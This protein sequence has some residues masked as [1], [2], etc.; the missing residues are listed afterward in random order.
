MTRRILVVALV[1]A[2]AAAAVWV[3]VRGIPGGAVA[4]APSQGAR[5]VAVEVA[6]AVKKK[7]PVQL[8]ALGN[9]SPIASVAVRPRIDSEI[10][11]I[12][13]ADGA[14]VRQGDVLVRLDSRAIDAQIQQAEGNLARD[15]AQLEG[16]ERDMRR[17]TDLVAKGATPILNLD[18]AKTQVGTF[19]GAIK[20]DQAQIQNLKVQL[21]YCTIKAPISGRISVAA[22]K[23]GNFVRVADSQPIATII[24]IAPI[25][26][27]FTVPQASLP[28]I[29][30]ALAAETA[31]VMAITPGESRSASGAVTM[32]ENTVDGMTGLVTIR[33]TMP[34]TDDLLWPGTLVN[35]QLTLRDEE[36]VVVPTAA[37]QVSQQ[38]TFVFVVRDGKAAV[39]PV[40]VAR[41]AGRETVL[42]SGLQG[43]ETV[44][45]DGFL[46]LTNGA[47]VAVRG[48]KPD[49]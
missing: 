21:S 10:T 32:I 34:N 3:V 18:N 48:N 26:V 27:T 11:A 24:Q 15:Q 47:R 30:K 38:G 44:V 35:V 8:S 23:V 19:A 20:A 29:R 17:Y 7:S 46:Q 4:Q 13:F 22:L 6:T 9:V 36:A 39:Q 43:A 37:V 45:T 1:T 41:V 14:M 28:D 49:A 42:E 5:P 40:K 12:E 25:Y 2:I 16:A 31:T 33:A